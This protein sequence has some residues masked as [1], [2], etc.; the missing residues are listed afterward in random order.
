VALAL[1]G[2]HSPLNV[3]A[4]GGAQTITWSGPETELNLTGPASLIARG[5]AFLA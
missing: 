2:C 1:H 3:I 5:E 4:P